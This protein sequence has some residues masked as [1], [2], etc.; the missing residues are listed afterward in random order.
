MSDTQQGQG[1]ERELLWSN[2]DIEQLAHDYTLIATDHQRLPYVK[3]GDCV[4]WLKKV[5]NH[6]EAE[7]NDLRAT[8]ARLTQELAEA[9]QWQHA[10][11]EA[12]A[13]GVE[14]MPLEQLSQWTSVR[15]VQ[16]SATNTPQEGE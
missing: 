7:R 4:L 2:L 16:E 12:I 14:L 1:V 13:L 3:H 6:Y 9:Q 8:V 11:Q 10:A 5:R 15:A